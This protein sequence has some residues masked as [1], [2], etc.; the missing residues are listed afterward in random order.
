MLLVAGASC[1]GAD[2]G[3]KGRTSREWIGALNDPDSIVRRDAAFALGRILEINPSTAGVVDALVA[4]L[5]DTS[6]VVRL[7]AGNSLLRGSALNDAAVPGLLRALDDSA[8]AHTREHA[9]S[10]LGYASP[11]AAPRIVPVLVVKVRSDPDATTRAAAAAAIGRLRPTG[12]DAAAALRSAMADAS[13][14]VRQDALESLARLPQHPAPADLPLLAAAL[15]DSAPGVRAAAAYALADVGT[16]AASTAP[17]LV[18]LV[19]DPDPDVRRAAVRALGSVG[20]NRDVTM[21]ALQ[22]ALR[23][24][25]AG[26]QA[27]ARAAMQRLGSVQ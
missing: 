14:A 3:Y 4:T 1:S 18:G 8:H 22:R 17:A 9:T 23:D 11:Q 27:E 10:L 26:V 20:A 13:P 2:P 5:G 16:D 25:S 24:S 6:D 15:Q 12:A 21:P 19:S 7:E